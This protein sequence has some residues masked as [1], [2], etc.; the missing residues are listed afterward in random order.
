[1]LKVNISCYL[2]GKDDGVP[3]A[4]GVDR[5]YYTTPDV[6]NIVECSNCKLGYLNPRPAVSEL[7]VIYPSNYYSY[8]MDIDPSKLGVA[9]RLR[10]KVHGRRFRSLLQHLD[11]R[12]AIDLLDVGCGDGWMLYLFKSADPKRI[13]T[14][15]VDI[16]EQVC[17]AARAR[18]HIVYCGLFEDTDFDQKFDVINLS[19]V[20]EH[21]TDPVA[22]VKKSFTSLRPGGILILETPSRDSWDARFFRS[23][24]WGSYHI[25]RHFTFFNP[26]TIERLG[27][28]AG[29][30]MAE[31]R[32]S[33]APTQWVWTMHNVFYGRKSAISKYL[34]KIFEPADCFTSGFKPFLLLGFFTVFDWIGLKLTGQTSNMT[35]VLKKSAS[36]S[37]N[38]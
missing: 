31:I 8:H 19:N 21:V 28:E 16:N 30:S 4:S 14:F 13:K 36:N 35:V 10:H 23:G 33:P 34:A 3:I 12:E 2:C 29:L 7:P 38:S 6:F 5:E 1:M 11:G 18:G 22:V 24:N 25:P 20:I 17:A 32:F 15:G 9:S 37:A 26:K 27:L